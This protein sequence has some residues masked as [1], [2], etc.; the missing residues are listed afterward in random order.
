MLITLPDSTRR[1]LTEAFELWFLGDRRV[2]T[3]PA[4]KQ[5]LRATQHRSELVTQNAIRATYDLLS[6]FEP[7]AF[8]L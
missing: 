8:A 7:S 4:D 5:T 2:A 6:H 3:L 1:T